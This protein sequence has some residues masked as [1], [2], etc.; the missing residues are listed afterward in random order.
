VVKKEWIREILESLIKTSNEYGGYSKREIEDSIL[1]CRGA[2]PRTIRTW[3]NALWRLGYLNQSELD[4]Y[5]LNLGK[6]SELEIEIPRLVDPHQA[7]LSFGGT[8]THTQTSVKE[9]VGKE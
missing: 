2:D 4:I 7:Q 1:E 8:H 5:N 3:F 9:D 6:L